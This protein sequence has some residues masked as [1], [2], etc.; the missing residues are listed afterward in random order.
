M[1]EGSKDTSDSDEVEEE[2]KTLS[3]AQKIRAPNQKIKGLND[4][5]EE[6]K[7][8]TDDDE[9]DKHSDV[10]CASDDECENNEHGE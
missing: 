8:E 10:D 6:D 1:K 7:S 5:G 4:A 3:F 9:N 2:S